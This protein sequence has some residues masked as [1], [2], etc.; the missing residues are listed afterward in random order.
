[1]ATAGAIDREDLRPTFELVGEVAGGFAG[2][3]AANRLLAPAVERAA[4]EFQREYICERYSQ[5]LIDEIARRQALVLE[6]PASRSGRNAIFA[7]TNLLDGAWRGDAN[8]LA[9]IR[10]GKTFILQEQ[11]DEFF[12][13]RMHH[14]QVADRAG[15]L[16]REGILVWRGRAR[17]NAEVAAGAD[18]QR[19]R[20]LLVA[21][22]HSEA[23]AVM[24]AM[25]KYTNMD[26]VTSEG[27]MVRLFKE[28]YP[29]AGVTNVRRVATKHKKTLPWH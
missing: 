5:G 1:G 3:G 11:L 27:R 2:V 12:S 8:A 20:E 26:A 18:L 19:I 7:D 22:G 24:A 28:T 9:E 14:W 15:F 29:Q 13:S 6:F 17:M 23:D 4:V 10:A 25:A 21:D 16:Q